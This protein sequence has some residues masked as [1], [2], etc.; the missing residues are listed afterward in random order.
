MESDYDDTFA[1]EMVVI[2]YFSFITF[3]VVI[4]S[5]SVILTMYIPGINFCPNM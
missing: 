5:P 3:K 1:R 2:F 4:L